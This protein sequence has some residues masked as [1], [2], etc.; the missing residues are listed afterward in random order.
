MSPYTFALM[1][2][3]ATLVLMV[4][5]LRTRRMREKYAVWWTLLAVAVLVLAL[6]PRVLEWTAHLVGINEPTNLLFLAS[7]SVLFAVCIQFSTELSSLYEDRRVLSE[8]LAILRLEVRHLSDRVAVL[9]TDVPVGPFPA[10]GNPAA[11]LT[12]CRVAGYVALGPDRC[13]RGTVNPG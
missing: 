5:L 7:G 6:N 13:Q 8:E 2:S 10:A 1:L 11:D 9:R 4:G 12:Q 3:I